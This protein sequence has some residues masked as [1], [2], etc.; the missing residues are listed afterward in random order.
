MP[1]YYHFS[2]N[3]HKRRRDMGQEIV[4]EHLDHIA[5]VIFNRP[6]RRNAI[7]YPMW[8]ELQRLM[9]QFEADQDVRV[10]VFR[11]AGDHAFSAGADITEFGEKRSN[12]DQA[13]SYA[14]AYEGAMQAI[15]NLSKPTISLI[16]GACTGGGCELACATDIRIAADNARFGIPIA[17]LGLVVGYW[18]MR[19]LVHLIGPG[20]TMDLLLSGRLI[21][22][23][24]AHSLGLVTRVVPLAEVE[25]ATEELANQVAHLAPLVHK[26][27]KQILR[28]VL[29]NPSLH[30]LT[31][32]EESLPYAC[33]DTED[34]RDGYRAF[35]EKRPPKFI[36]R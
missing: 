12:S 5:T 36:G 22:S 33:F 26:W 32:E 11:G 31:P 15:H 28:T 19:S 14:K 16:K 20:A 7:N 23:K 29:T 30:G 13:Q 24:E 18:E 2:P 4:V 6:E 3:S 27:H 21:D 8:L 10:V 17:R 9:K 1:A 34:F 25:S 35:L